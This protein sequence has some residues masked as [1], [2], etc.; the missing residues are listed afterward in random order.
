[1][2]LY[3]NNKDRVGK[4]KTINTVDGVFYPSKLTEAQRNTYG[5]FDIEMVSPPNRRYYTYTESKSLIGN[6]FK[7]SFV[8]VDRNVSDVKALMVKDLDEAENRYRD[9]AIVTTVKGIKVRGTRE[10]LDSFERGSKRG[11]LEI[12]DK[13]RKKHTLTKQEIDQ[14]AIDIETNGM[15]LFQKAGNIFDA[16]DGFTTVAECILYEATPEDHVVTE[17]EAGADIEGLLTVGQVIVRYK[18]NVKEWL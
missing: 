5:Y 12:R 3:D 14:I 7:N 18:N 16:I 9:A 6:K 17:E 4:F 2:K 8:V 15:I 10:D 11:I 13:D 1:M